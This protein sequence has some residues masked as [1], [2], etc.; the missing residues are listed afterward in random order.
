MVLYTFYYKSIIPVLE[1]MMHDTVASRAGD[2]S[3]AS[4][5]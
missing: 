2:P 1:S 4:M 3:A 5:E